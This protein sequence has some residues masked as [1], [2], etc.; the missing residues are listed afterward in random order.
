MSSPNPGR[1]GERVENLA[2]FAALIAG[3]AAT[4]VLLAFVAVPRPALEVVAVVVG[5]VYVATPV[6][7]IFRAADYPWTPALA[8]GF[9]LVGLAIHVGLALLSSALGSSGATSAI[10]YAL[11]QTGLLVWCVGL[12]AFLATMLKEKNLLIPVSLFLAAFDVFLVLTPVGPARVIMQA[13]PEVFE[14]IS[15]S[16]PRVEEAPAFGPVSPMAH[17]GPADFLFMA[18]FFVALFRFEMRTR[19]T[20]VWLV[21][22]LAVYLGFVLL[23]GPLPALVPIGLCVLVVNWREF[24]LSRQEWLAT[25]VVALVAGAIILWG[26]TRPAPLV[27]PASEAVSP[28]GSESASSPPIVP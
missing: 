24:R 10:L 15:W 14:A 9:V 19:E 13:Q 18:M 6:L 12:G 23:V 25:A 3:L 22:T 21:P 26:A 11:S 4:T 27:E 20:I 5:I 8:V 16:V 28:A 1:F 7:A 2:A 17:I